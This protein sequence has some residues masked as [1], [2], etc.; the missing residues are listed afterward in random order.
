MMAY[1]EPV[2]ASVV[3]CSL[4]FQAANICAPYDKCSQPVNTPLHHTELKVFSNMC[5]IP[6]R[7]L[8]F[9]HIFLCSGEPLQTIMAD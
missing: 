2:K 3:D 7:S 1:S 4:C 6:L 5:D 8:S 9:W